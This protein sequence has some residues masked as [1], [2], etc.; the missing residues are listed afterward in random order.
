MCLLIGNTST[1]NFIEEIV[2]FKE[3]M[4]ASAISLCYQLLVLYLK[5]TNK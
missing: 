5:K 1:A 4:L 3:Y 2:A